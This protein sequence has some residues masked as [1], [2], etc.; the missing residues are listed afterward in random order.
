MKLSHAAI[1]SDYARFGLVAHAFG[2]TDS[3]WYTNSMEAFVASYRAGFRM[4]EADM[5][6]LGDG[7]AIVAHD[8]LESSYGL[9]KRF[10][11]STWDEVRGSAFSQ[12]GRRLSPVLGM[13]E[14]ATLLDRHPDALLIADL[15]E[16]KSAKDAPRILEQFAKHAPRS[17]L[18]RTY[19]HLKDAIELQAMR[20]VYPFSDYILALY[21]TQWQGRMPDNEAVDF[22]FA[23]GIGG[24]MMWHRPNDPILS[25][26]ENNR[27]HQRFSLGFA[28]RFQA[29][30][31][32][33]YVHDMTVPDPAFRARGVGVYSKGWR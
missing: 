31:I 29:L 21:R 3:L 15:K 23:S 13:L 30:G 9:T 24:V 14:L 4:F 6:L 22:A 2:A 20:S 12:N 16:R 27:R 7:T 26:A 8:G 1:V 28:E 25:L 10:H 32:A 18:D 11:E 33:V 5:V 17:V 19:P